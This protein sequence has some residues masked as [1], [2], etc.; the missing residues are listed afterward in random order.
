MDILRTVATATLATALLFG[1][2]SPAFA[3]DEDTSGPYVSIEL[4]PLIPGG[5]YD[6]SAWVTDE[7]AVDRVEWWIDG[8]LRSTAASFRYTFTGASRTVDVL[9]NAWDSVGNLTTYTGEM[10]LDTQAPEV[11]WVTPRNGAIIPG[12]NL[13][14]TIIAVDDVSGEVGAG[15]KGGSR[16]EPGTEFTS[17]TAAGP[18][19]KRQ[20]VWTV[21]DEV[22]NTTVARRTVTVDR[23]APKVAFSKAPKNK[24]KVKGKVAITASASDKNGVAKVQLLV[25]GKAVA[26]DTKAAYKF[27]LNTAKYG[28]TIKVQLRAYDKAGNLRKTTT[29]TWTKKK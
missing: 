24:A 13:T 15:M 20:V 26:T 21:W 18:E 12:G 28:K 10:E 4:E 19:G 2:G 7:S 8:K 9:F 22:G 29:R 17:R 23:T 27:T 3:A 16:V 25:N 1:A 11:E 14:S 6:F 5:A